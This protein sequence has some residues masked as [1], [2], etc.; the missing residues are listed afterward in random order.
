MTSAA[1]IEISNVSKADSLVF[2]VTVR[3]DGSQSR[4]RVTMSRD[5]AAQF[6]QEPERLI[7]AAFRFLLDRERKESILSRFDI[8]VIGSYFPEF[9]REM[10]RYLAGL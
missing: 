2:D 9:S 4:H 6:A 10:P 1:I 7:E 3:D 5:W 8:S